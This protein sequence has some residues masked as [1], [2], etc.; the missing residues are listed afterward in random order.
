M[1]VADGSRRGGSRY[2]RSPGRA[3]F[4][5]SQFGLEGFQLGGSRSVTTGK[6]VGGKVAVIVL[7]RNVWCQSRRR[8]ER[9]FDDHHRDQSS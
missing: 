8:L 9:T 5:L 7:F 3:S 4:Q 6:G 1:I 2:S